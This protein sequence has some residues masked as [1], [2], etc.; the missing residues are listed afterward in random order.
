MNEELIPH[1]SSF[2]L[3]LAGPLLALG[4][5]FL[6]LRTMAPSLGGTIDSAEFQQ[7]TYTLS[8][9]HPTGYPLYLMLG[10]LWIMIFPFGD[11]AFRVNLLSAIFAAL[12]VWV[13][14]AIIRRLTVSG[15][16]MR[17]APILA[18]AAGA[19]LFAVQPVPWAQAGV[20]EINSLNTLLVGL[21][22]LAMLEWSV[23]RLPLP[24]VGFA[25]GLALSHHRQALLYF[26]IMFL[27]GFAAMRWGTPRRITGRQVALSVVLLLLPF[28][29]YLY[30]PLRSGT[31]EGFW[32]QVL[33]ESALPV[34]SGALE[35]PLLPRLRALTQ[36][37]IFL[38]AQGLGLLAL[39]L[40]GVAFALVQVV[41]PGAGA[42]MTVEGRVPRTARWA[43]AVAL[44]LAL[45]FFMGLGFATLYD[46]LDVSDY[47]AVPVFLWCAL[48]GVGVAALLAIGGMLA[49]TLHIPLRSVGPIVPVAMVA[50]CAFTAYRSL[51]RPDIR[52]DFSDLDR[53]A[54]WS[55]IVERS[56][57]VER[58]AFLVADW[59]EANEARYIQQVEGW[60]PD[61]CLARAT[62][63][64]RD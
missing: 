42:S 38:G 25:Y 63:P 50:L 55:R 40:L 3:K 37:Q 18:G 49:R 30:I 29:A 58:G 61:L 26:P 62:W 44:I 8:T 21:S 57:E 36:E 52:V 43:G 45:A 56:S 20:A 60:R 53:R 24:A 51:H 41:R 12:A 17:H 47:L 16:T 4:S 34:I 32:P 27:L 11:P 22:L 23:G 64:I 13:L 6:Y 48:A 1:P 33:G 9:V 15:G 28:A 10:R 54:F 14:F 2:I 39:G 46:I 7:A 5:L 19:A 31:W 59:P 35:R